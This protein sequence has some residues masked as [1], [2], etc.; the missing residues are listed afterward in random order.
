MSS[1]QNAGPRQKVLFI[2]THNSARS[3]MAEGILNSLY[4]NRFEAYSAGTEP[5]TP[6]PLAVSAMSEIG[7]DISHGRSKHF[8]EFVGKDID[9]VVT[10]C[11]EAKENCPFFPGAKEYAHHG[12]ED[13]AANTSSHEA[14]ASFRQVRDEL[15]DWIMK[16][17]G[18]QTADRVDKGTSFKLQLE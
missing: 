14:L 6:N 2:C 7:I 17:F 16:A 15:K 12:V 4:G 3:Q 11:N 10:L 1:R 8:S 5:T 9:Y 13:P 18:D